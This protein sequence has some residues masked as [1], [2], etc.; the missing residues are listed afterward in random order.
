MSFPPTPIPSHSAIRRQLAFMLGRQQL[1]I[2]VQNELEAEEPDD[3]ER[4]LL[5]GLVAN[6]RVGPF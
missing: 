4:E 1:F 3:D 5:A 2:D 6:V